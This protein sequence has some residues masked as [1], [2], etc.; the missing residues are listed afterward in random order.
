MHMM[1]IDCCNEHEITPWSI[2]SLPS[3]HKAK[4]VFIHRL[5]AIAWLGL[6]S[7]VQH[8]GEENVMG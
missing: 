7:M 2:W 5:V 3:E 4:S 8:L 1:M 6:P